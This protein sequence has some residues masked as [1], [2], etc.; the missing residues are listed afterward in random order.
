[1]LERGERSDEGFEFLLVH[2]LEVGGIHY[3]ITLPWFDRNTRSILRAFGQLRVLPPWAKKES[4][5]ALVGGYPLI[6]GQRTSLPPSIVQ[7]EPH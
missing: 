1:L 6:R 2:G 4:P 3:S 5:K 7:P